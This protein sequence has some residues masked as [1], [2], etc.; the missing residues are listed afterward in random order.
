MSSESEPPLTAFLDKLSKTGLDNTRIQKDSLVV[1]KYDL[2]ELGKKS[3]EVSME[4]EHLLLLKRTPTRFL[5]STVI[6]W[7]YLTTS[8]LHNYKSTGIFADQ[9][10]QLH[11]IYAQGTARSS[12]TKREEENPSG[13]IEKIEQPYLD[14]SNN[15]D[16]I[17]SGFTVYITLYSKMYHDNDRFGGKAIITTPE[18]VGLVSMKDEVFDSVL[19]ALPI[20]SFWLGTCFTFSNWY[21]TKYGGNFFD[22]LLRHWLDFISNDFSMG[23]G[24]YWKK[25]WLDF[26]SMGIG[27]YWKKELTIQY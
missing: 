10:Y 22:A 18:E 20:L 8:H 25:N 12:E 5:F 24:C 13:V 11:Q 27:Y 21:T 16:N 26:F 1:A 15:Y 3:P 17:P 14:L 9:T 2:P 4:A 23:I 7:F 19:V 6:D